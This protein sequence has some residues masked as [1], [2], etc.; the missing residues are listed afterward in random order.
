MLLLFC[1]NLVPLFSS[2]AHNDWALKGA[3]RRRSRLVLLFR[4]FPSSFDLTGAHDL[5]DFYDVL[6][7]YVSPLVPAL[8]TSSSLAE[9]SV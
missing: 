3:V 8:A 6:G 9:S 2:W 1:R 4:P 7:V 5:T